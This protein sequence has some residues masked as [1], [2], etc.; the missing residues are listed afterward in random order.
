MRAIQVA[1]V[2]ILLG[3]GAD[4]KWLGRQVV[5]LTAAAGPQGGYAERAVVSESGLVAV[6]GDPG[7]LQQGLSLLHDG[8]TASWN[9]CGAWAPR[10]STTAHRSGHRSFGGKPAA[11]GPM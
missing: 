8:P 5:A 7:V 3:D 1:G 4:R 9:C 11:P 10:R 6:P 2:V